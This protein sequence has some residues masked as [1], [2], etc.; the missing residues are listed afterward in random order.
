MGESGAMACWHCGRAI[1]TRARIG[2]RDTCAGC[3][4]DLRCCRQCRFHDPPSA[5]QCREPQAER[6]VDRERS[7]FCEWFSPAAGGGA[8]GDRAAARTR[9]EAMF[10]RKDQ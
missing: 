2:R 8:V 7:N 5:N 3:G 6:Q 10:R 4:R 9:L 1:E